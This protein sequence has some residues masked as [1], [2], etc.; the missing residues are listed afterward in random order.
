MAQ[1]EAAPAAKR[2]QILLGAETVFTEC[3]YEGASM[4]RIA[5]EA[6]VSKGTLYNYFD[7]KSKLFAVFFEQK[8]SLTLLHI[9]QQANDEEDPVAALRAI[10][11]RMVE[12]ILSPAS[13]T[14]YRIVVSEAIKFPHLA[15][16][17]WEAGPCRAV[18]H[19]AAWI[20]RQVAGG[21][22]RVD[23]PPFA[24]EQ[25]LALCQTRIGTERRLQIAGQTSQA[26]IERVVQGAVQ[27]FL[28][29][30][31]AE[32]LAPGEIKS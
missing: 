2:R 21:R 5:A 30:Y 11:L 25:F 20:G 1:H 24:A 31:G 6:G 4:S 26:E 3:G 16:V 8:A 29:G 12:M 9:F 13:L 28:R 17:Y 23:D 32:S 7:S 19:M 27:L 10:G 22:L 18:D 14:L 15:E